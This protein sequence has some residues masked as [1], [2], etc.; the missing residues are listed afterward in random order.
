VR[1]LPRR[2]GALSEVV[3]AAASR[4]RAA[5]RLILFNSLLAL[6]PPLFHLLFSSPVALA[7]VGRLFVLSL[8]YSNVIGS[9]AAGALTWTFGPLARLGP[10]RRWPL[11]LTLLLLVAAVGCA[12][13]GALVTAVG[14]FRGA[15]YRSHFMGS[16]KIA[17]LITL[18]AGGGAAMFETMR[19][20]LRSS[21]LELRRQLLERQRV[22]ALATEA[23]LAAL[24]SRIH[25]HFLFNALNSISSLIQEDPRRAERLLEQIAA[26]L[27]F[28]LDTSSE[29]LVTL[30]QEMRIVTG[31]LEIERARFGERLR[32]TL[33]APPALHARPVPALSLQSLVD[34]S[35]KYAIVPRREGGTI[36]V[37]ARMTGDILR[38]E[39]WDD[40]PGFEPDAAPDGHGL[41][42][43][44]ARLAALFGGRA[45]LTVERREGGTAVAISWPVPPAGTGDPLP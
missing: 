40:G 20:R 9:L 8:I 37:R 42:N 17:A 43:L 27:R 30:G 36:A 18:V 22:Q 14:Y 5:G 23:R 38:L 24:E 4:L 13:G 45:A 11:T 44:R 2:V 1:R 21:N 19:G 35:V 25:P 10:W 26:L 29:G 6:L 39:V 15:E 28:S 12:I 32:Y 33:D 41:D 34:N 3:P 31:Y 7:Q 16:F